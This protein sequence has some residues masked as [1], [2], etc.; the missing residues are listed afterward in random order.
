ME[1]EEE[2]Q[3]QQQEEE[4]EETRSRNCIYCPRECMPR[5]TRA[6][7]LAARAVRVEDRRRQSRLLDAALRMTGLCM[8]FGGRLT[9]KESHADESLA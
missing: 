5:L 9:D 6:P 2:E 7:P 1:E 4:E 8:R 3:Q